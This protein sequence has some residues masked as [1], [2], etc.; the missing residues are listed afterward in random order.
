MSAEPETAVEIA[1]VVA[2]REASPVEMV[3]RA[4]GRL[5]RWQPA[6]NAFSEV[7]AD[8]AL[9]AARQAER[10]L[11]AGVEAGPLT[12]VPVTV[13]DAFDV[14]GHQTTG[15]CAG[16]AGNVAARDAELVRR[17]RRA[18]AIIVGKTN[19]HELGC[20]STGLVSSCGPVANPCDTA[21]IAGGSSSGSAAAI[22]SGIVPLALG[23]D[24]GGSIRVPASFCGTLG[25]K[26]TPG[27]LPLDG[28]LP[29][30]SSLDCPGLMAGSASDLR[31]LWRTL[32][33]P[34]AA[35][36][37][38]ACRVAV[39]S[40]FF[41]TGIHPEVGAAIERVTRGLESVGAVVD[42]VG[43][44]GIRD[45]PEVW[46]QLAWPEVAAIHGQLL[47]RR[48]QLSA[49][50][51][52]LLEQGSALPPARREAARQ[53]AG[54]VAAWFLERL[55]GA[56]I[57][58]APSTPYPPPYAE[59]EWVAVGPGHR[60]DV[61]LGGASRLCRPVNLSRLPALAIPAGRTSEGLPLGV[62]LLAAP[63]EEELL[64]SIAVL[65]ERDG[66]PDPRR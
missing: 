4:L 47:E 26:P 58:V 27:R 63:G 39:L 36:R 10:T 64:L 24:A 3:L 41:A 1:A 62:Q 42:Q 18:G 28:V 65:L 57:L 46:N 55:Q 2:D 11:A 60:L 34:P 15:C 5:E 52:A 59:A 7:F 19:Q 17:L 9:A 40:G 53:R 25:L 45:A 21:R 56:D 49:R 44:E 50:T 12:G 30:T 16:Y 22:A 13:K 33:G 29:M 54:Q 14:A 8:E 43:G 66:D 23:T 32:A 37:G 35:S 31:L 51:A 61:H 6:I 38:G 48:E 20:G